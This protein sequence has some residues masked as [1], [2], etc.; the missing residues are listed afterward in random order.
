MTCSRARSAR[1]KASWCAR[2]W[3]S[4]H[5]RCGDIAHTS[6]T[7]WTDF[8]GFE[9]TGADM[10]FTITTAALVDGDSGSPLYVRLN[11]TNPTYRAAMGVV[12]HEFISCKAS[13][14]PHLPHDSDCGHGV[15]FAVIARAFS[16]WPTSVTIYH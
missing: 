4:D 14:E 12:D 2:P 13:E 15:Y 8:G 16:A 1:S 3:E 5:I 6:V 9:V 11:D 7:W 10:D